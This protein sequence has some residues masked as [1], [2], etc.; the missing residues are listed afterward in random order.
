MPGVVRNFLNTLVAISCIAGSSSSYANITYY[1]DNHF[2]PD[3]SV[4]GS[5]TTD[6]TVG[7]LSDSNF[8]AWDLTATEGAQ[9]FHLYHPTWNDPPVS[10]ISLANASGWLRATD[11]QIVATFDPGNHLYSAFIVFADW[12]SL[13][14][15]YV[16]ETGIADALITEQ[17]EP[18]AS[19]FNG[20]NYVVASTVPLPAPLG[21]LALATVCF[22]S[23]A[24]TDGRPEAT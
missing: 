10:S 24:R 23:V 20:T 18:Y 21:L 9:V 14:E 2:G 13:W 4:V 19:R 22:F 12:F 16:A 5:L 11:T 7:P 15:I 3:A 8:V 17:L 6:G 1:V